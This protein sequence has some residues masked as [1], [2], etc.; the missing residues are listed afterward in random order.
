MSFSNDMSPQRRPTMTSVEAAALL[1]SEGRTTDPEKASLLQ[2]GKIL[3]PDGLTRAHFRRAMGFDYSV[4]HDDKIGKWIIRDDEL[5]IQVMT[6]Y[7]DD[8]DETNAERIAKAC[9]K[10]KAK[11]DRQ[12]NALEGETV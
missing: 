10:L 11:H 3:D 1:I 6:P 4:L 12:K 8:S 5:G 2:D 9:I 7:S